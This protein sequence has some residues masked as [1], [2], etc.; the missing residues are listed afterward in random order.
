MSGGLEQPSFQYSN[1]KLLTSVFF[2]TWQ[3]SVGD[4]QTPSFFLVGWMDENSS[5]VLSVRQDL[6][7]M[8]FLVKEVIEVSFYCCEKP[9]N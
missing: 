1:S 7:S 3:Q 9:P 2:I 8:L 4:N 6:S 5:S